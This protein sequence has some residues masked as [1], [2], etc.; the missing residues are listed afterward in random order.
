LIDVRLLFLSYASFPY[1]TS[2]VKFR[3]PKALRV[4][5]LADVAGSREIMSA[6]FQSYTLLG[7]RRAHAFTLVELL[8]VIAII[9]ILIS[10]LLPA[11]QAAR[12]A[13]RKMSCANN[14]HQIGLGLHNH[15]AA[16]GSFPP[17]TLE[18]RNAYR[19]A[20]GSSNPGVN[21]AW[22]ALILPYMEQAALGNELDF[23][24]AF[25]SPE[26]AEAAS[27]PLSVFVCPAVPTS[28]ELRQGRGPCH[29]GG[30]SGMQRPELLGIMLYDVPRWSGGKVIGISSAKPIRAV[31][32]LDGLSNT[33]IVA[34][35]GVS[36]DGQWISAG[37]VFEVAFG[38]NDADA[39][40]MDNEIR[41]FH[42]GG[43]NATF[44][45]GSGRFLSEGLDREVVAALC[46]RAEGE[47]INY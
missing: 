39:P 32:I 13:A 28:D 22:S 30:V 34:E 42:P 36:T 38:V 12:G 9:G 5:E 46:T 3:P 27:H 19:F 15:H 7:K 21:I 45:D 33:L 6:R 47:V 43:A 11:V 2:G 41:A 35:D 44:A 14:I 40:K 26:N 18:Y 20:Y 31:D 1:G 29:Y 17:G 23:T 4:C 24:K 10:L 16:L 25:D 37:N 8:V